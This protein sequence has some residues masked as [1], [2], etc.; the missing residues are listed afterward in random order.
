[1][2][3]TVVLS[4]GLY[5]HLINV[6]RFFVLTSNGQFYGSNDDQLMLQ[7]RFIIKKISECGS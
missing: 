5:Q 4:R 2:L 6:N 7:E 1:M 3:F